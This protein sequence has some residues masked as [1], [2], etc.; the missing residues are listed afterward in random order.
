MRTFIK[1][2]HLTWNT[3]IVRSVFN[4]DFLEIAV[5]ILMITQCAVQSIITRFFRSSEGHPALVVLP[6]SGRTRRGIISWISCLKTLI[7]PYNK[8]K[9]F[10]LQYPLVVWE[11]LSLIMIQLQW[12]HHV[13]YAILFPLGAWGFR[14]PVFVRKLLLDSRNKK[15]ELPPW[16]WTSVKL[17]P[18]GVWSSYFIHRTQDSKKHLY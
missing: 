12:L 9:R 13:K 10:D 3:F 4:L 8:G 6:L 16:K 1:A 15:K 5:I 18:K 2:C 11:V 17:G 14:G 7:C